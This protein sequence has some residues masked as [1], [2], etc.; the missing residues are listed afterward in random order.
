MKDSP[1]PTAHGAWLILATAILL[2]VLSGEEAGAGT[3]AL[4]LS[5]VFGFCAVDRLLCGLKD[6]ERHPVAL[7][8]GLVYAAVGFLAG[9]FAAAEVGP[10]R[11]LWIGGAAPFL[12]L[13][14][15]WLARRPRYRRAF[16]VFG[17]VSLSLVLPAVS[18]STGC[19]V[20]WPMFA[21][22]AVFAL[23]VMHASFRT[24]AHLQPRQ[25]QLARWSGVAGGLVVLALF[26][27]GG[28]SVPLALAVAIGL[29]EPWAPDWK[30]LPAKRIGWR[31]TALISLFP[32]ALLL[33]GWLLG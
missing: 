32:L 33:E 4:S 22:S 12:G 29:A 14:A 9:V 21:L 15:W 28:I 18:L 31:E 23:H 30:P 11:L 2:G 16:E 10:L 20:G 5:A 1:V 17:M 7:R 3:L 26:G 19:P 8:L 24:R 6:P 13:L 25:R 27:S